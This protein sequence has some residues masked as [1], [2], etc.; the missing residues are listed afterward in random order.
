MEIRPILSTLRRHKTAAALIVLEIALSCAIVCNALFLISQ[1]IDSISQPSGIAEHELLRVAIVGVG[2]DANADAIT[3]EDLA[4]LRSVP[5]VASATTTNQ[6][7]FQ[8]GSNNSGI[9]LT[10]DQVRPTLNAATYRV[11]L[12]GLKTYGLKIIAGRDF[13]PDE[14][15]QG[16]EIE[17]IVN[18]KR[19]VATIIDSTMAEKIFPG[20][21]ANAA[22]GKTIYMG[23]IP[24]NI[25]G[26]VETLA[27]PNINM[28]NSTYS[29]IWPI[30]ESYND[31]NY[32][33]RANDP[34][35]RGEILEASIDALNKVNNNR[36]VIYQQTYD[37][38]R[39]KHFSADRDM[40]GLLVVVSA[41]LLLVTALGIVGLASFWVQQRTRQIGVRRA[42]GATK[43][44]ILHYFQTE[45]F[46]LATAGIIIGMLLAFGINQLLMSKYELPRLPWQYL[47]IGAV[48][49]WLLGQISVLWPAKRAADVPPA[50]A[51]RSA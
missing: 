8:N 12:D 32:L 20:G 7:P 45:N 50:I 48:V 51:T 30:R 40:I 21:N 25:V 5:G 15:K 22:V 27:R 6:V 44:Q 34:A 14:Y 46:I 23:N 16:K 17:A 9:S 19:S 10:P 2:E 47:P 4:A 31:T 24:M 1:R 38:I 37:E 49:L 33:I 35:R 13:Q 41:A 26:V 29:L 3:Q 28:G 43:A 39:A 36:M 42:L 11:G 18:E